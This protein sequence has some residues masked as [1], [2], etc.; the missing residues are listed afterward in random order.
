MSDDIKRPEACEPHIY[1]MKLKKMIKKMIEDTKRSGARCNR[2]TLQLINKIYV[3][4][5]RETLVPES[6]ELHYASEELEDEYSFKGS[7]VLHRVYQFPKTPLKFY[8]ELTAE[9]TKLVLIYDNWK[10]KWQVNEC[11]QE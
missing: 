5:D 10:S 4:F 1:I 11:K 2:A 6:I 7:Q 8:K 9:T 3:I